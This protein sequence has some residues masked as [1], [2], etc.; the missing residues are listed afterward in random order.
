MT[1][2]QT[3]NTISYLLIDKNDRNFPMS[4]M[5][6]NKCCLIFLIH[7]GNQLSDNFDKANVGSAGT[8]MHGNSHDHLFH[9]QSLETLKL[10]GTWEEVY[11]Q[12]TK[13]ESM[14]MRVFM[15]H[16]LE[17]VRLCNKENSHGMT[18][19]NSSLAII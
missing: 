16:S 9:L 11:F 1:N 7:S 15:H 6:M 5:L 8:M 4:Y 18:P 10:E 12:F 13:L 19:I 3:I 14:T 17:L 2:M